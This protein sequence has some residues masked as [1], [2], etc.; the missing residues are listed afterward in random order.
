MADFVDLWAFDTQMTVA[1]TGVQNGTT[2]TATVQA[3]A[4]GTS[5]MNM[6]VKEDDGTVLD[7]LLV[8]PYS[9]SAVLNFVGSGN[10]YSVTGSL[11]VNDAD[12]AKIAANFQSANVRFE[13]LIAGNPYSNTIY[14]SGY[15]S[16]AAGP[17]ILVG[18]SD[19]YKWEFKGATDAISLADNI[20]SYDTGNMVVYEFN[21]NYGSLQQFL[22][23]NG[24]E[25]LGMLNAT[26]VPVPAA[27]LLGFLGLGAAGLKL[28]KSA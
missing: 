17:S 1:P 28:R 15:L 19:P 16:P 27:V 9:L 10:S 11:V 3:R 24:A 5:Y 14:V 23:A 25:A 26:V 12:G 20:A 18:N 21:V 2:A 6:F 4:P 7:S 8:E 13:S 22:A